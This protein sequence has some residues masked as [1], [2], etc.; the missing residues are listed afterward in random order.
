MFTKTKSFIRLPIFKALISL[1]I[2]IILANLFQAMYQLTDSFWVGR[3]GSA[4]LAAVSICTPIIFF[5]VSL[6]IG[7]AIA[8]S[9]FTAQYFGA[10][11]HSMLSHA[12]AQTTLMIF[13]TSIIFSTVGYIFSPQILYFMGANDEIFH[14]A[15]GFL[16]V[17]FLAI[18]FNYT[19]F[20]FQSIMRSIG[21]PQIPVYIIIGTVLLNF[22]LDPLFIFGWGSLPAF[23]V[24]GA[25]VATIITQAI[26]SII[27]FSILFGGKF[28]IQLRF[29][30]FIPDFKF[31]KKSFLIGL[32]ASIDQ[33]SRSLSMAVMTSLIA[34]FGTT[35]VASYGAG[36]NIFQVVMFVGIGLAV[37][38][39]TL[40]GQ[41]IGANR[42]D[43]AVKVSK[44]SAVIS[45][46][47]LSFLGLLVFIFAKSLVAFFIPN[48]PAVIKVGVE[49]L[50]ISAICF[51]FIGVQMSLGNVF[52]A[53]GQTTISMFLTILSQWLI[54]VPLSYFLSKTSFGL[55]GIWYAIPFT[56]IFITIV[57]F[58]LYSQGSW[59]KV[60]II[61]RDILV[62]D[63]AEE[64]L[65]EEGRH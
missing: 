40:V 50:R 14:T 42:L 20:M 3:L 6:G 25:V 28:G 11:N 44:I 15:L 21:R 60:K 61:E 56:N 24:Q 52:S 23:G 32:P 29:K 58:I 17:S 4:A 22:I 38:N 49:Y 30:D 41:N 16:R 19:F 57:A 54:Q 10:K 7:F 33:S 31:I 13:L 59:K 9:I 53:A 64:T 8:G 47:S 27:G 46:L 63:V 45:F 62:G 26:A 48:D 39:G 5:T 36:S 43:Q 2:P 18:I 12:A 65:V 34:G 51:G 1:A 55:N 35:A 37:A